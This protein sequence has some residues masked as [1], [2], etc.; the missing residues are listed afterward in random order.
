MDCNEKRYAIREIADL[1]G[2]KPVTLR[3]WQR[4]YNLVQPL[5]T[6]KGHR[7]YTADD[8][9]K[10]KTIQSWLNKGV[11]IGKVKSLLESEVVSSAVEDANQL[12]EVSDI[13]DALA[14]LDGG[15]TDRLI[16][17]VLKEYPL[18]IVESKFVIPILGAIQFLK[19]GPRTL[20]LALFK[21]MFIKHLTLM[22]TSESKRG[23]RLDKLM[24]NLDEAG[25]IYAWLYYAQLI[26]QGESVV[27]LDGVEETS[28]LFTDVTQYQTIYVFAQKSLPEK[29]L[30]T[31]VEAQQREGNN[32]RVSP[33]IAHLMDVRKGAVS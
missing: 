33:V 32:I 9:E 25:N 5:R 27:F 4:R 15:K 6:E 3:A 11:S 20:Q 8:L 13:L 10:I 23:H 29:Q 18:I 22:V 12:E 7:L 30:D 17:M 19:L 31:I 16:A 24:V 26:E 2:I 21:T 1:T 14:D 28:A